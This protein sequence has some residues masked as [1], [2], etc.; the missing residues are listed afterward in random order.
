MAADWCITV[1]RREVIET[2]W[3]NY[4][5]LSWF[6]MLLAMLLFSAGVIALLFWLVRAYTGSQGTADPAIEKLR[7]RL[8]AGEIS[9]D[10]F[11]KT[12]RILQG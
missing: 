3:S 11:E 5:G 9:Q 2:M 12:K 4:N 1:G 6:W 7:R 10:E 8:A